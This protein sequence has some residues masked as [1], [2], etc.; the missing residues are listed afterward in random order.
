MLKIINYV[1]NASTWSHHNIEN[2]KEHKY[3]SKYS[4]YR[5]CGHMGIG[6][7]VN[8]HSYVREHLISNIH[9][10]YGHIGCMVNFLH[11]PLRIILYPI[12]IVVLDLN[13]IAVVTLFTSDPF[14]RPVATLSGALLPPLPDLDSHCY[15]PRRHAVR[16]AHQAP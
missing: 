12:C 16:H 7:M 3:N 15:D 11:V 8:T 1:F 13:E 4:R 2:T 6:Y 10:M 9:N 5:L 14:T